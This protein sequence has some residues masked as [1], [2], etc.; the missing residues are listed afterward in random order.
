MG[1]ETDV[2]NTGCGSPCVRCE[3]VE[4]DEKISY[5]CMIPQSGTRIEVR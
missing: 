5:V 1:I 4:E 2:R 3:T